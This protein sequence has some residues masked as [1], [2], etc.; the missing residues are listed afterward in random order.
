MP[1]IVNPSTDPKNDALFGKYL[2]N[3][4]QI[5]IKISQNDKCG[6]GPRIPILIISPY[7]KVNF[8]DHTLTDFASI[9]KFIEDNWK[10]GKIGNGSFDSIANSLNNMFDFIK[11]I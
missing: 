5:K 7:A 8:V 3:P 11:K 1:T 4:S 2:C 10:L 9:I 6:Y